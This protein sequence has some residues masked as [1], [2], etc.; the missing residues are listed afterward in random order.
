MH[1]L[2]PVHAPPHPKGV[3]LHVLL[4]VRQAA[5]HVVRLARLDRVGAGCSLVRNS[6]ALEGST[7][8][9]VR[10]GGDMQVLDARG[11]LDH[12]PGSQGTSSRRACPP[13]LCLQ[14]RLHAVQHQGIVTRLVGAHE[15]IGGRHQAQCHPISPVGS[16]HS[17]IM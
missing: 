3:Q 6:T 9:A 15:G 16:E 10:E 12:L 11:L 13:L 17:K 7:S 5:R 8:G 2:L 1:Q 14:T 4:L